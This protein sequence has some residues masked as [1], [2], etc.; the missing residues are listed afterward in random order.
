MH[1]GVR[2]SAMSFLK[3]MMAKPVVRYGVLLAGGLLWTIGLIDQASA[4][5]TV[6]YLLMSLLVAVVAIL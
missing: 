3:S 1:A 6:K 2:N 4:E 5:A